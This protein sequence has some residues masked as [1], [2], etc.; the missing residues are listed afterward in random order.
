MRLLPAHPRLSR[1]G[2][3]P[4]SPEKRPNRRNMLLPKTGLTNAAIPKLMDYS[5]IL[6]PAER[7]ALR[8]IVETAEVVR[9]NGHVI[10][11]ARVSA[12]TMDSLATFET[13]REDLEENGD[14][15]LVNED[16][17]NDSSADRE[18]VL[19]SRLEARRGYIAERQERHRAT[20]NVTKD[21]D[22]LQKIERQVSA[23]A[24]KKRKRVQIEDRKGATS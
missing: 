12:A 16:G 20:Y 17:T 19:P 24:A 13:S 18:E 21:R 22:E 7:R 5:T 4:A 9:E 10:L 3:V 6:C 2:F 15:E 23:L 1:E 8:E 11:V 14:H